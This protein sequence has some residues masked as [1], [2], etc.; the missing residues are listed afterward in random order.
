MDCKVLNHV[1]SYLISCRQ[2]GRDPHVIKTAHLDAQSCFRLNGDNGCRKY[3]EF[4]RLFSSLNTKLYTEFSIKLYVK[5]Y[6]NPRCCHLRI[7]HQER[8]IAET[9]KLCSFI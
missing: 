8:N 5:Q 9:E 1:T 6:R 3:L 7:I 4:C 2:G